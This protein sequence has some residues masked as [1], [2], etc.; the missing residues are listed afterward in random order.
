[1]ERVTSDLTMTTGVALAPAS[2]GIWIRHRA[3][4]P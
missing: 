3:S 2:I 1:M 4:G